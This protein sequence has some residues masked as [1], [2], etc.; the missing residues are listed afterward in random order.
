MAEAS[1]GEPPSRRARDLAL[2]VPLFGSFAPMPPLA[3][4][5]AG[6]EYAIAGVPFVVVYLFGLWLALIVAAFVLARRLR[7]ADGSERR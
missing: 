3:G 5:V 2:I 4:L 6:S 1:G 7:R